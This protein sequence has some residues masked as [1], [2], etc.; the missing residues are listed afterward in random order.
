M[1]CVCL[2]YWGMPLVPLVCRLMLLV[3]VLV[4]DLLGLLLCFVWQVVKACIKSVWVWIGGMLGCGY[5]VQD[6]IGLFP[7]CGRD[8]SFLVHV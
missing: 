5:M 3:V 6:G 7:V 4:H 8:K 1:D 2:S